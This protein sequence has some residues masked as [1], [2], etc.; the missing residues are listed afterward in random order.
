MSA[1]PAHARHGDLGGVSRPFQSN[2][3]WTAAGDQSLATFGSCSRFYWLPTTTL[4]PGLAD[5]CGT[6]FAPPPAL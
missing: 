5:P 3:L 4:L 1:A 2:P 6:F